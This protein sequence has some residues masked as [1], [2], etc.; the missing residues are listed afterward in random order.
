MREY[1]RQL[2]LFTEVSRAEANRSAWQETKK[3]KTIPVISGRNFRGW[4]ESLD[5]VGLW[6]KTYLEYSVSRQTQSVPTWSVKATKSGYLIMKLRVSVRNT[7]GNEYSLLRTP[8]AHC[9]RG[10]RKPETFRKRMEKGLP[11]QLND[12]I[13]HLYPH[14]MPTPTQFDATCGDL[15][16]KEYTGKN[17]HSMKLIQAVK[18]LPTPTANDAKNNGN[19]SRANRHSLGLNGTAGG[20]LNPEWVEIFMGFPRGWTA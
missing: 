10:F 2:M 8:D 17:K 5:R 15:K 6:V 20:S 18:L 16:G 9:D 14:I 12:Q 1:P 7:E 13:A 3:G 19:P 4:S 11:L